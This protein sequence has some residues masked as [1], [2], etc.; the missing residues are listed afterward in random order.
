MELVRR[1]RLRGRRN[2]ARTPG[3]DPRAAVAARHTFFERLGDLLITGP[4]GTNV[5]DRGFL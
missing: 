3:L 2:C 4:T 5:G 1:R